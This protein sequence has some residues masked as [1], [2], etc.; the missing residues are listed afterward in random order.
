M[1][2]RVWRRRDAVT[3]FTTANA[4]EA[5]PNERSFTTRQVIQAV[6]PDHDLSIITGVGVLRCSQPIGG[7]EYVAMWNRGFPDEVVIEARLWEGLDRF[8]FKDAFFYPITTLQS[9]N[10]CQSR[11][12]QHLVIYA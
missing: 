2:R 7:E 11:S 10:Y 3:H 1:S 5:W 9:L 6:G 8:R 4:R 12:G